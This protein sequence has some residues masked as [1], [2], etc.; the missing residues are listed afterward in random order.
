ME[1]LDYVRVYLNDIFIVTKSI[2]TDHLNKLDTVIQRLHTAGL[3][4]N[5]E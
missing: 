2:Y 1:G 3:K 5:I 4:I